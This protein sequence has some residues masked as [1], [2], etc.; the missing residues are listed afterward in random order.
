MSSSRQVRNA[1]DGDGH[2]SMRAARAA[3][4]DGQPLW[5]D[6]PLITTVICGQTGEALDFRAV[7]G[8]NLASL[9]ERRDRAREGAIRCAPAF[10]CAM[11]FE[12]VLIRGGVIPDRFHFAHYRDHPTCP[13]QTGQ[14]LTQDEINARKYNGAKTSVLHHQ[15]EAWLVASLQADPLFGEIHRERVVSA[16]PGVWRKPDVQCRYRGQPIAFEIQLSTTFHDVVVRRRLFYES[17]GWLLIWVFAKFEAGQRRLMEDDIFFANNE[18][19][20]VVNQATVTA[21]QAQGR[22]VMECCW[23]SHSLGAAPEVSRKMV[24]FEEVTLDVGRQRAYHVDVQAERAAARELKADALRREIEAEWQTNPSRCEAT[25]A[26]WSQRFQECGVSVRSHLSDLERILLTALYSSR[27]NRPWGQNREH[28]IQ[29]VHQYFDV[30]HVTKWFAHALRC[31]GRFSS[32]RQEGRPKFEGDAWVSSFDAKVR[33]TRL[34]YELAEHAGGLATPEAYRPLIEFLFPELG[35]L[36]CVEAV[37]D[38]G[39]FEADEPDEF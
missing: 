30:P 20:F 36:P 34:H 5:V 7:I 38:P 23:S 31:H 39:D 1:W 33:R 25:W 17:Q 12:P 21:S 26:T 13:Y 8:T 32:L 15:M 35:Q 2:D 27:H 10:R 19:A 28:L 29:V 6:A 22:Y 14:H 11:C 3:H 37:S 18:N 16:A 9:H 24:P 4:R